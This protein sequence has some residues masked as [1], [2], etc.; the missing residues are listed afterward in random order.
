MVR[1][2]KNWNRLKGIQKSYS[3]KRLHQ[4]REDGDWSAFMDVY[5]LLVYRM[6][7]FPHRDDFMDLVAMDA[8]LAKRDGDENPTMALLANTYYTLNHC[9]EW[10]GG[11][12]RLK[13]ACPIEDFQWCWIKTMSGDLWARQLDQAT[14]RT[15]R[16]YP[17]WN[18]REEIIINC[19]GFPNVPLLGTQGA[20]N[21][22]LKLAS[23]QAGYPVIKVPLV[24]AMT[25]F[26]KLEEAVTALAFAEQEVSREHQLSDK[27]SK[28]ARVEEKDRIKIGSCLK[29]TN[30]EMCFR[31]AE[32][33]RVVLEKE[34]L[35]EAL[36]ALKE[37]E[38]EREAQLYL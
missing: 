34:Q 11:N 14:E 26:R 38:V 6:V 2:K 5:R 30:Q 24:E 9:C 7:L 18:E 33:D 28:R 21:Y 8:Y 19:G 10:K 4:F 12:L 20:I 35:K 27:I 32:Q 16:W 17:M 36:S 1:E 23:R 15:I 25:S 29:A 22:N 31:R 13:T 37:R 3:E